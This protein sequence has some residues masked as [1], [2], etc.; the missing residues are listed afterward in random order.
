MIEPHTDEAF[1]QEMTGADLLAAYQRTDGASAEVRRLLA[2]LQRR[3]L[4]L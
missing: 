1:I 2:K 3:W 4:D